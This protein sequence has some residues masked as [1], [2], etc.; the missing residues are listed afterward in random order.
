MKEFV[1]SARI[2]PRVVAAMMLVIAG[3]TYAQDPADA[4]WQK[5]VQSLTPGTLVQMDLVDGSSIQGTILST[6]DRDV[7][8]N[9]KTRVP[10]PPWTVGFSEIKSI[11]LR[12]AGLS[13]GAKVAVGIGS[14]F[15]VFAVMMLVAVTAIY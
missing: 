9:P 11:E 6:T 3:P 10:V 13:P 7:V 12:K 2:V 4:V 1:M 8:I 14:G 5:F 15:V